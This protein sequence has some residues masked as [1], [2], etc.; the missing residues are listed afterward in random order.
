M[1]FDRA[2]FADGGGSVLIPN[3]D[4]FVGSSPPFPI[5]LSSHIESRSSAQSDCGAAL[6]FTFIC[7]SGDMCLQNIFLILP[8]HVCKYI[9]FIMIE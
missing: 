5:S 4:F 1:F 9:Q 7:S 3:R 2:L 6:E 8:K